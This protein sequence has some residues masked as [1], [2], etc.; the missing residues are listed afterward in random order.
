MEMRASDHR[1]LRLNFALEAEDKNKGRFLFDKVCLGREGTE[2]AKR[3]PS[4]NLNS[5]TR[6]DQLKLD[7]E[8]EIAKQFPN[9]Q[10]MRKLKY[11]LAVALDDEER[12]WR[13][14][15]RME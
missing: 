1:T 11:E 8:K 7:L 6:I 5:K 10:R 13:Q 14:Y 15:S 3:K 9:S 12:F 2:L 4:G